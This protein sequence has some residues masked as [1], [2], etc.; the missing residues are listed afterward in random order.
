M[1]SSTRGWPPFTLARSPRRAAHA[2]RIVSSFTAEGVSLT[3]MASVPSGLEWS[4]SAAALAMYSV[5]TTSG[6]LRPAAVPAAA[7]TPAPA[8]AATAAAAGAPAPSK[9]EK[10]AKPKKE[11]ASKAAPVPAAAAG[12]PKKYVP[13]PVADVP[14]NRRE[15]LVRLR[16]PA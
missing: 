1:R 3:V 13:P 16:L 2:R 10:A 14:R 4:E 7:P 9:A 12:A 8:A 6:G 15:P 5:V 11:A